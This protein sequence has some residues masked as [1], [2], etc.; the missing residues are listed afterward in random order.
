M[1]YKL[2]K[3]FFI[4]QNYAN[5]IGAC[6][7]YILNYGDEEEDVVRSVL[8]FLKNTVILGI[9]LCIEDGNVPEKDEMDFLNKYNDI[10]AKGKKGLKIEELLELHTN[11]QYI[12]EILFVSKGRAGYHD[13]LVYL[14]NGID[15]GVDEDGYDNDWA[16]GEGE[17]RQEFRRKIVDLLSRVKDTNVENYGELS[18]I[19]PYIV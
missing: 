13:L 3:G 1:T 19:L 17:V 12:Y 15:T 2:D 9:Q 16:W 14:L 11:E 5:T 7:G 4:L 18:D 10:I 8:E 6:C